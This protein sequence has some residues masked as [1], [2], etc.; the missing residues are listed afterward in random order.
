MKKQTLIYIFPMVL[1]IG[2]LEAKP[3]YFTYNEDGS[4]KTRGVYKTDEKGV[5]R[6]FTVY[7]GEGKKQYIEIPYYSSEGTLLRADQLAPDGKVLK[8]IVPVG[9]QLIILSPSGDILDKQPFESHS[10]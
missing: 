6:E 4:V 5:V 1:F 10:D 3:D 8:V 9:N 2:L 7:D